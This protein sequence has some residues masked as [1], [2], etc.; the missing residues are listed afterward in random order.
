FSEYKLPSSLLKHFPAYKAG[1]RVTYKDGVTDNSA[2]VL[3]NVLSDLDMTVNVKSCIDFYFEGDNTIDNLKNLEKKVCNPLIEKAEFFLCENSYLNNFYKESISFQPLLNHSQEVELFSVE[4]GIGYFEALSKERCLALEKHELEVILK[5]FKDSSFLAQRRDMGLPAEITDV[6]LEILAQTWSEHC[7]HKI[8]S[9]EIEYENSK[10]EREV[11]SSL[12]KNYIKKVTNDLKNDNKLDWLISVFDD[13]AGVVRFDQNIDLC[14]KVETHNSPSALDPYGG[15]LTGILGVNRDILGTGLGAKPIANMDVLCFGPLNI[16]EKYPNTFPLN[17]LSPSELLTGVHKGIV[18]GGNKSGIPMVNGGIVFDEDYSGKPLVYCGTIGVM[19]QKINDSIEGAKKYTKAGDLIVVV[20]GAVGADGIHGAT[21]SSLDLNEDSPLS[22]VQI[23]DPFTQKKVSDFLLKARDLF[24]FTGLTDNGAGGISS[25]LGEMAELTN[26]AQLDLSLCTLKYPGLAPWE[27]MISESQERM[28]FSVDKGKIDEFLE[29]ARFYDVDAQVLGKFTDTGYFHVT[30]GDSIVAYLPLDF[31]HNGLPKMQLKAKSTDLYEWSS[32]FNKKNKYQSS[33]LESA[34]YKVLSSENIRSK[35]HWV[36]QF[37]QG[38]QGST[39]TRPYEGNNVSIAQNGSL[40]SLENYGGTT[41]N[42][43]AFSHGMAPRS[44]SCGGYKMAIRSVDEAMRN[45]ICAGGNPELI[46]GLDNFCWPDPIESSKNPDGAYKLGHLVETCKG[47]YDICYDYGIPLVS[48]KD[49]MKNDYN[50]KNN[51]GPVKISIKPTL[52]I[53]LMAQANTSVKTNSCFS[54]P[55]EFIYLL[56]A[57][58]N[59]LDPKGSEFLRLYEYESDTIDKFETKDA[60]RLYKNIH[61]ALNEN[62]FHTIH[63]VS[64]GGLL[65]TI[66]ELSFEN[67]IGANINFSDTY[68]ENFDLETVLFSETPGRI[69]C[70]VSKE[71]QSSF[72]S[73]FKNDFTLLGETTSHFSLNF[74][75]L[76]KK[77][78]LDGQSVLDQWETKWN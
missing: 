56:G 74:S 59:S 47:L 2:K 27:I 54:K 73:L 38:V 57:N 22:A 30:Y 17:H 12:F 23:G 66:S 14:V 52:L 1:A 39:K 70:S 15:A 6:E 62:I 53:S 26:G 40:I 21:F 25:S 20:G 28:S 32:V 46:C 19:P 41:G 10:G 13:N 49:S 9:G 75:L 35:N 7:K 78:H 76:D 61:N 55:D 43:I 48:G 50:G 72:E 18:D 24:L 77:L 42:G 31:L 71:K 5:Q 65:T 67:R 69:I 16:Q 64:D 36:S 45:I 51:E 29:L 58:G 11:I 3:K 33:D 8:F 60:F 44:S 68:L 37:D 4:K 34:C 63:D